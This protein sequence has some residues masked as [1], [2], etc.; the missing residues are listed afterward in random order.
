MLFSVIT[1]TATCIGSI[2]SEF[3][4][5]A[6]QQ[7]AISDLIKLSSTEIPSEYITE[8]SDSTKPEALEWLVINT[9]SKFFART[10]ERYGLQIPQWIVDNDIR[11][12]ETAEKAGFISEIP[13]SNQKI[14]CVAILGATGTE[15][16]KRIEYVKELIESNRI[17]QDSIF[18]LTGA[19]YT[20][21]G[22]SPEQLEN[23]QTCGFIKQDGGYN[24]LDKLATTHSIKINNVTETHIMED[25]YEKIIGSPAPH[26]IDTKVS[27]IRPDT[28]DTIVAFTN[29]PEYKRC[30]HTAF[31]SRAPNIKAQHIA[32]ASVHNRMKLTNTFET[33]G[34]SANPNEI[35]YK[36][37]VA[38]HIVMPI[39]GVIY[40]QYVEVC[41][42]LSIN[43]K[44]C[45]AEYRDN[46]L[47]YKTLQKKEKLSSKHLDTPKED[48]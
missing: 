41:K 39:G 20:T 34:G 9:Q 22:C 24:Y 12:I 2:L 42:K 23:H 47:S 10:N 26:V 1:M 11:I 16:K 33:I 30:H 6:K 40:G 21:Q 32:I 38:H 5:D 3:S 18:L 37:S 31:V 45:T 25:Q 15:I 4:F 27:K 36:P 13:P 28:A 29:A 7:E 8:C 17:K 35:V 44:N 46:N 48:L 19:R 14:D 43:Q